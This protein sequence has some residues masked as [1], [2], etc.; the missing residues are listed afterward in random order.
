MSDPVKE[1]GHLFLN[2]IW[3][4]LTIPLRRRLQTLA[5]AGVCS[6]IFVAPFICL[7]FTFYV[8][9]FTPYWPLMCIYYLWFLADFNT[10]ENGGRDIRFFS[11]NFPWTRSAEYFPISVHKTVDL[12]PSKSYLFGY[13]PHG[14]ICLGAIHMITNGLNSTFINLFPGLRPRLCMLSFWFKIPI[15]RE[16]I[17]AAVIPPTKTSIKNY[18]NKGP[19][20]VA[21]LVVGGAAESLLAKPNYPKILLKPRFG[22]IKCAVTSGVPLVPVFGFGENDIWDQDPQPEEGTFAWKMNKYLNKKF[23]VEVPK[24]KGRGF[25]NYTGGVLPFRRPIHVVVGKPIQTIKNANPSA[26]YLREVHAKYIE[27]LLEIYNEN[28]EKYVLP[29]NGKIPDL[30]IT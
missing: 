3:A 8:T 28:K 11:H 22:F 19:G 24:F 2:K 15:F 17:M 1:D 30:V 18:L 4:P 21:M 29:V 23:G 5:V 25:L 26:E 9:F 14:I 12:D 7:F 27:G 10:P 20:R 13:H 6:V 16:Y